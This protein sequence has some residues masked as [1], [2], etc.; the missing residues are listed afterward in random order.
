MDFGLLPLWISAEFSSVASERYRGASERYRGADQG[1]GLH[2]RSSNNS[3]E[4]ILLNVDTRIGSQQNTAL[5]IVYIM[6]LELRDMYTLR[7]RLL[8]RIAGLSRRRM[9]MLIVHSASYYFKQK[10][11]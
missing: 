5:T 7:M 10:G 2:F 9:P 8:V 11:G 3:S 4:L 1:Y 6:L